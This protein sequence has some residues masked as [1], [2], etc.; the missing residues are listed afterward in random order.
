MSDKTFTQRVT[1]AVNSQGGLLQLGETSTTA[2]RG[3]RG[4]T[5]YDH[6]QVTTGNPH[7]TTATDV[8]ALNRDG[9]NANSDVDLN[10]YSLNAKSLH[11]KGTG[12]TGHLG[13]KH[14]S[15]GIT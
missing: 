15:A 6:S 12:G 4:T 11:V 3:D 14:Q 10:T 2:Y 1:D 13:L 5:A 8:D 7:G 9:S